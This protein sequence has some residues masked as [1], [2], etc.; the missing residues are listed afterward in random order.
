MSI[1][2]PHTAPSSRSLAVGLR[3]GAA[4]ESRS[5]NLGL[6]A[7]GAMLQGGAPALETTN[8]DL[9]EKSGERQPR[10]AVQ[11]R[12]STHH[13][14]Y[15]H[16]HGCGDAVSDIRA[17][18]YHKGLGKRTVLALATTYGIV[19][20][21]GGHVWDCSER[22]CGTTFWFLCGG[23]RR[24]LEPGHE[25]LS[26]EEHHGSEA[27]LVVEDDCVALMALPYP[28]KADAGEL[29]IVL[30]TRFQAADSGGLPLWRTA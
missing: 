29:H 21:S 6:S 30:E 1:C 22:G 11:P 20:Q 2:S 7:G 27:L 13:K 14:R 4:Y 3:W 26:R 18:S 10:G 8:L 16:G 5:M 12:C 23:D 17:L 24:R 15:R 9:T 19:K 28:W 25:C